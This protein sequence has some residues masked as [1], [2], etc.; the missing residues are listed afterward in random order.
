M[1]ESQLAMELP[2]TV[3]QDRGAVRQVG[4]AARLALRPVA[5]VVLTDHAVWPGHPDQRA[6]IDEQAFEPERAVVGA[7]DKTAVHAERM[8]EADGDSAGR[9]EQRERVPGEHDR[10][11]DD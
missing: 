5:D 3:A 7:V 4:M 2:E 1:L 10:H 11:A 9:Q 8:A 6:A